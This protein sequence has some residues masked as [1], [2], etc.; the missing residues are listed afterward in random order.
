[1]KA[2]NVYRVTVKRIVVKR[3]QDR[4]WTDVTIAFRYLRE[5]TDCK[6]NT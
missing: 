4:V 3:N 6:C 5:T 2:H 1:M